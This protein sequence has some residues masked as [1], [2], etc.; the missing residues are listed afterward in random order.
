MDVEFAQALERIKKKDPTLYQV[1]SAAS[2]RS[3]ALASPPIQRVRRG[4]PP[5]PPPRTHGT[6]DRAVAGAMRRRA[7]WGW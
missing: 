3:P 4:L 2:V 6:C 1:S 5:P 7:R